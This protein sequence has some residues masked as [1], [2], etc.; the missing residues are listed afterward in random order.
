M[1]LAMWQCRRHLWRRGSFQVVSIAIFVGR[2]SLLYSLP[3]HPR[4]PVLP[5]SRTA[6]LPYFLAHSLPYFRTLSRRV[7]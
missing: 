7:C 4:T 5:Y 2:Y 6:V 3:V 1:R